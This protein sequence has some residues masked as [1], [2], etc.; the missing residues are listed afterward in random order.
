MEKQPMTV[1]NSGAHATEGIDSGLTLCKSN[2][3]EITRTKQGC[4]HHIL[5]E[6]LVARMYKNIL[7]RQTKQVI[8]EQNSRSNYP[9]HMYSVE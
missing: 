1:P 7:K 2:S 3:K 4:V 6:E 9:T 8:N 5:S